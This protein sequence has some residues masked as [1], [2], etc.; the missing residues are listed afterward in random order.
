MSVPTMRGWRAAAH[1]R[2]DL[3]SSISTRWKLGREFYRKLTARETNRILA[4]AN[5][6]VVNVHK[7]TY[8]SNDTEFM[9]GADVAVEVRQANAVTR[10]IRTDANDAANLSSFERELFALG[11]AGFD[12]GVIPG[13][14]MRIGPM[15]DPRARSMN[16]DCSGTRRQLAPSVGTQPQESAREGSRTLTPCGGGT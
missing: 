1:R 10:V 11:A 7:G 4:L 2:L 8:G 9:D 6:F 13:V 12:A 15:G 14:R 3:T 16:P 5:T